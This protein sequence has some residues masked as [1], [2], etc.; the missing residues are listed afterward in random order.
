M[1]W[2]CVMRGAGYDVGWGGVGWGQ[3]MWYD[4]VCGW[5]GWHVMGGGGEVHV[6]SW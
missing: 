6:V 3:V 1:V 5:M 2:H 4:V